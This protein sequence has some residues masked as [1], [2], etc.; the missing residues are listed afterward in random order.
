MTQQSKGRRVRHVAEE[1]ASAHALGSAS[2]VPHSPSA[3]ETALLA[4]TLVISCDAGGNVREVSAGGLAVL[5]WTSD[6][7]RARPLSAFSAHEG[8][9]GDDFAGCWRAMLQGRSWTGSF[10]LA[11][12]RDGERW[13]SGTLI[14]DCAQPGAASR[15]TLV[16]HTL[17]TPPLVG[18]PLPEAAPVPVKDPLLLRALAA[19]PAAYFITDASLCIRHVTA[20]M[21]ALLARRAAALQQVLPGFRAEAVVGLCAD[22]LS[23]DPARTRSRL[24]ELTKPVEFALQC[25]DCT[26]LQHAA[27]LRD[28]HGALE[29]FV[30]SWDDVSARVEAEEAML[31]VL[32]SAAAGDFAQRLGAEHMAGAFR[33]VGVHVNS[34]LDTVSGALRHVRTALAH[35]GDMVADMKGTGGEL[36]TGALALNRA[37]G[38]AAG[39]L[40]RA[41]AMVTAN[42]DNA[43]LANRLVQQTS[44]AARDGQTR[45][46][47]M[48]SAMGEISGSA[49]QIAN[50]IRVIDEI[51]FQ[52][53]LLA[54]NAAVEAARAGKH[55]KGFAVVAQEVR[56]L[57]ERSAKA[58]RETAKLIE[59]SVGKV[60][61]GVRIA[62]ATSGA[63]R[64]IIGNVAKVVEL[65]GQIASAS[66][67]QARTI[68]EVR[69]GIS[70]VTD[71]AEHSG[72]LSGRVGSAAEEVLQHVEAVRGRLASYVLP[73]ANLADGL[74]EG[75]DPELVQQIAAMLVK[76]GNLPAVLLARPPHNDAQ[77]KRRSGT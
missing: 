6:A 62:E 69:T 9:A 39:G 45:M 10:R 11:T 60:Q 1:S 36:A 29:G 19:T 48:T 7:L 31:G 53:N 42:A 26:I 16:A 64:E 37:A 76:Q 50:I 70:R 75:V 17:D 20:A 32:K 27:A 18:R 57:A 74:P 40:S 12:A 30:I 4:Q 24:L 55:G 21:Q 43:A 72:E 2:E 25:G 65:A 14:V 33:N 46:T 77:A 34:V 68:E 54:L 15:A 71:S 49:Q 63:L 59:D 61:Q 35:C 67:E 51:A 47:E 66:T 38:D 23:K 3:F 8:A 22:R 13:F 28:A 56:N 41:A 52:T 58:A 5:G 44:Q 73:E